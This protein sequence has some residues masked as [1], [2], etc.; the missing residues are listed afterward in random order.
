VVDSPAAISHAYETGKGAIR[1]RA[2]ASH[3]PR[4]ERRVGATGIE[5]LGSGQWQLVVSE[6][7]YMVQKGKL[8]EQL[9]PR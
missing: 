6:D 5:K 4:R 1:V 7:P 9:P 8:I 3:G 2:R